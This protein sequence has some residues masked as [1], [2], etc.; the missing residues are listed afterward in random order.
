MYVLFQ[1][2]S[3]EYLKHI[4]AV[5]VNKQ[6]KFEVFYML[7]VYLAPVVEAAIILDIATFL[8]EK[9]VSSKIKIIQLFD[10]AVSP[11]NYAIIAQK[12]SKW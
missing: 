7:R 1:I 6:W 8:Q 9:S 5:H 3:R 11:R 4:Y 2:P 12:S 10:S